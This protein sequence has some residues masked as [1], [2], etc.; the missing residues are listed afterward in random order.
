MGLYGNILTAPDGSIFTFDALYTFGNNK[1]D[2]LKKQMQLSSLAESDNIF[3]GRFVYFTDTHEIYMK[4]VIT[5]ERDNEIISTKI[6]VLIAD[7]TFIEQIA[8]ATTDDWIEIIVDDNGNLSI[9]HRGPIIDLTTAS[10]K[11][12]SYQEVNLISYIEQL[13]EKNDVKDIYVLTGLDSYT[14]A[15]EENK[16][17][18]EEGKG[19]KFNRQIYYTQEDG[20]YYRVGPEDEYN[21]DIK[22][23]LRNYSF[24]FNITTPKELYCL[25]DGKYVKIVENSSF[26]YNET[27]LL[28]TETIL[29]ARKD[30]DFFEE[31]PIDKNNGEIIY[32]SYIQDGVQLFI[33]LNETDI[34]TP[35]IPQASYNS[36]YVYYYRPYYKTAAFIPILKYDRKGHLYDLPTPIGQK[37]IKQTNEI[38]KQEEEIDFTL[39][40]NGGGF[41]E[42]YLT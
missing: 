25:E 6:Y 32:K 8:T 27:Y 7:L 5:E 19:F 20:A 37:S 30:L 36:S 34:F 38:T 4:S 22:Y 17:L 13:I 41:L 16:T 10:D 23:Y 9:K 39:V 14:L 15:S 2:E 31:I 29:T 26:Q 28:G 18:L 40:L 33:K 42:K 11:K 35:V 21:G 1:S 24:N 12:M 3:P